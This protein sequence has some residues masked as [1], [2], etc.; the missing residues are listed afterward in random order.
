MLKVGVDGAAIAQVLGRTPASK[1]AAPSEASGGGSKGGLIAA[2]LIVAALV[3]LVLW[4][5]VLS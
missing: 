2:L 1:P 5:A 3:G 4:K